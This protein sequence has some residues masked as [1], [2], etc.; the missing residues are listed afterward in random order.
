ME[1]NIEIRTFALIVENEVFGTLTV[2]DSAPNHARLWAGLSSNPI[3]VEST[4]I[5]NVQYGWI[6][7]GTEFLPPQGE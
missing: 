6:Y 3:V 5:D 2:P 1:K 4:G 7:N